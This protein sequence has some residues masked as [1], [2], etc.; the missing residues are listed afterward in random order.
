MLGSA[1]AEVSFETSSGLRRDLAGLRIDPR[2]VQ[3]IAERLG[4]EMA[5]DKRKDT[6]LFDDGELPP[7]LYLGH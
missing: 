5:E 1:A 2:Q 7:T 6:T 3:R 4:Q